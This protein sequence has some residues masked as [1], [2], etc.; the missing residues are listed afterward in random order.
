MWWKNTLAG[1][2]GAVIQNTAVMTEPLLNQGNRGKKFSG[3]CTFFHLSKAPEGTLLKFRKVTA[4]LLLTSLNYFSMWLFSQSK[5]SAI[6]FQEKTYLFQNKSL[7]NT[8]FFK[9]H[10]IIRENMPRPSVQSEKGKINN[11]WKNP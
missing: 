3:K 11:H 10:Q 6:C 8:M 5:M 1:W 2:E 4:Y 9:I 7:K